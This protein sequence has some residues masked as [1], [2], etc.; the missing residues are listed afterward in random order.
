M[1]L[2]RACQLKDFLGS[3]VWASQCTLTVLKAIIFHLWSILSIIKFLISAT[4]EVTVIA[5]QVMV[6][7]LIE[8][9]I[10]CSPIQQRIAQMYILLFA[11]LGIIENSLFPFS[12]DS[13]SYMQINIALL[14]LFFLLLPHSHTRAH[15]HTQTHIHYMLSVNFPVPLQPSASSVDIVYFTV[16]VSLNVMISPGEVSGCP[17]RGP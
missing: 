3:F 8:F 2:K 12:H 10:N 17:L 13:P 4:V 15:M 1:N 16:V 5:K 7:V 9:K 6:H 14:F 11:F